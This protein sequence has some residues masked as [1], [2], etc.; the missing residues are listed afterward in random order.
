MFA[1]IVSS[2]RSRSTSS[3]IFQL[4]GVRSRSRLLSVYPWNG[5]E[6]EICLFLSS[7]GGGSSFIIPFD[8]TSPSKDLLLLL[9][10]LNDD[11]SSDSGFVVCCAGFFLIWKKVQMNPPGLSLQVTCGPLCSCRILCRWF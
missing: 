7:G 11:E 3:I 2:W 9:E 8:G 4:W 5:V 1:S 10:L 6:I